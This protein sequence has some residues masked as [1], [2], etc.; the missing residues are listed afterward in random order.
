MNENQKALEV[1]QGLTL[2]FFGLR[3]EGPVGV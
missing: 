3:T 1:Y 2:T